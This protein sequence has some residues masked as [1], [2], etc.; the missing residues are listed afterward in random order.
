MSSRM[1]HCGGQEY[2]CQCHCQLG[3]LSE[4]LLSRLLSFASLQQ[5]LHPYCPSAVAVS[6]G[7]RLACGYILTENPSITMTFPRHKNMFQPLFQFRPLHFKKGEDSRHA[8]TL[9]GLMTHQL[10]GKLYK[11]AVVT[12][13]LLRASEMAQ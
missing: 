6:V 1:G 3:V 9:P 12:E 10:R 7:D 13:R 11:A 5:L 8:L 2:I 4:L